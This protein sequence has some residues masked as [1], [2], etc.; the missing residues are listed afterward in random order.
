M[1][2]VKTLVVV[3]PLVILLLAGLFLSSC[4]EQMIPIPPRPP[5]G[6]GRVL[7]I[8]EFTGV[9]CPPCAAGAIAIKNLAD[10]SE[11]AIIYYAIH[12]GFQSE[13]TSTSKYDFRYDDAVTFEN[14]AVFFGKPAASFNRIDIGNGETAKSNGS[15]W[16]PFIDAELEKRQVADILVSAEYNNETR[17][18]TIFVGVTAL[19]DING[20]INI[21]V[22]VSESNLID[23]QKSPTTTIQDFNHKHVMKSSLTSL[24]GDFLTETLLADETKNKTYSYTLPD[25]LNGEWNPENMEF[26]VFITAEARN[27]EIQQ[28]EQIHLLD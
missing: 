15:T 9:S 23:P 22:V 12:G 24:S 26:T 18:A 10:E 11:G 16:Q 28:A 14:S 19:E 17:Q 20:L 5:L 2:I 1:R 13:P 25:E 6:E 7:L 27:G 4:E 3:L 8:E 21:N